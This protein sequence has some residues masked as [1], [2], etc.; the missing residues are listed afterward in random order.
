M[1]PS[2]QYPPLKKLTGYKIKTQ[3]ETRNFGWHTDGTTRPYLI[4]S[5]AALIREE[6][7]EI[8]DEQA[9]KEYQTFIKYPDGH[10]EAQYGS[11]DDIVMAD[12]IAFMVHKHKPFIKNQEQFK[13]PWEFGYTR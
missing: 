5:F 8:Y 2:R 9:I 1:E 4:D 3:E 13:S 6:K 12:G 7:A 10:C 11:T